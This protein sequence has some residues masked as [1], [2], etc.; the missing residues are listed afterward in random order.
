M[1]ARGDS[2]ETIA[3]IIAECERA[4]DKHSKADSDCV[5]LKYKG[6]SAHVQKEIDAW[7]GVFHNHPQKPQ[8]FFGVDIESARIQFERLVDNYLNPKIS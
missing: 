6:M 2:R 1:L 7:R 5:E 4:E 3:E 8:A